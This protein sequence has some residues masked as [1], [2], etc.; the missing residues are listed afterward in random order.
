MITFLLPSY[1][2]GK[3]SDDEADDFKRLFRWGKRD[4]ESVF[5][6]EVKRRLMRYVLKLN[7]GLTVTSQTF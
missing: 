5:E 7:D 3:R 1:R 2:W 4:D 6:D